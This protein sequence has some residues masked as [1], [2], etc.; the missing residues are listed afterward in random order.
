MLEIDVGGTTRSAVFESVQGNEVRFSYSVTEQDID[1]DGVS[2]DADALTLGAGTAITDVQGRAAI[3]THAAVGD[4]REQLVNMSEVTILANS[5]EP[6]TENDNA[7]F[8]LSRTGSLSRALT[9]ELDYTQV[10][11]FVSRRTRPPR[12]CDLPAGTVEH[13]APS[14]AV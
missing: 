6:V 5:E 14:R 12:D 13:P 10:G 2:V 3:L 7:S 4:D 11:D 1:S 8:T 9:V